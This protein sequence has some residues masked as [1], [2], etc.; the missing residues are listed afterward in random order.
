MSC[1]RSFVRFVRRIAFP[2]YCAEVCGWEAI[3]WVSS[4]LGS[5]SLSCGFCQLWKGMDGYQPD[6]ILSRGSFYSELFSWV[7]QVID[8][9][10]QVHH[11]CFIRCGPAL[12]REEESLVN[13]H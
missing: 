10:Y 3:S 5:K 12:E 8:Y 11:Q 1:S 13:F 6:G 7:L 2:V 4:M 9:T